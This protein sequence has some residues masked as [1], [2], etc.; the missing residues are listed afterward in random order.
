MTNDGMMK[1]QKSGGDRKGRI[2]WWT[3][4]EKERA[5]CPGRA[6]LEKTSV[7]VAEGKMED[8]YELVKISK[9]EVIIYFEGG[10]IK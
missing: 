8:K 2:S 3:C 5:G 10:M 6:H 7:E 4:S 1:Y 9:L